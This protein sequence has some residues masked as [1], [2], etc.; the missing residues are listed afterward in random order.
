MEAVAFGIDLKDFV[1]VF[2]RL[3]N[4]H[5]MHEGWIEGIANFW[6]YFR[7]TFIGESGLNLVIDETKSLLVVLGFLAIRLSA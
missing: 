2:F 4:F 1:C 7:H 5:G 3:F 6:K